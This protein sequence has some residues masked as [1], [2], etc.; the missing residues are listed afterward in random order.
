MK[1][2]TFTIVT[3]K[4]QSLNYG[5]TIGNVS[6]LKKLTIGNDTPRRLITYVSDKALKYDIKKR[7]RESFD[8]RLMD[9]NVSEIIKGCVENI[10]N[11]KGEFNYQKFYEEMVKNYEEFD[12]FGGMFADIGGVYSD[13]KKKKIEINNVKVEVD[14]DTTKLQR[15]AP[16]RVTNA[17]SISEFVYDSNLLHDIDAYNRYIQFT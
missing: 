2:I 5:E 9:N 1:A 4:A 12:L 15:T 10:Q 6:T 13:K 7:G 16:V 3:H 14:I 11:G 8:W 17:Y